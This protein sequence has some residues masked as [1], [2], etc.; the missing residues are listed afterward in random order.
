M[1][2]KTDPWF[3]QRYGCLIAPAIVDVAGKA[4]TR[5]QVFNPYAEQVTIPGDAVMASMDETSVKRMLVHEES[6]LDRHNYQST[7]RVV[8]ERKLPGSS[9]R[10]T[11]GQVDSPEEPMMVPPHLQTQFERSTAKWNKEEWRAINCLLNDF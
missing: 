11:A 6:L 2:V 3:K 7:Q 10:D 9:H 1:L 5:V 8:L 4:T